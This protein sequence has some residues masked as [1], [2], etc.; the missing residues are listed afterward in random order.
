MT[1]MLHAGAAPVEYDALRE[2]TVPA[3]TPS[4]VPMGLAV[5]MGILFVTQTDQLVMLCTILCVLGQQIV[6]KP[7]KIVALLE[8]APIG[9]DERTSEGGTL[10]V[11]ASIPDWT[12]IPV[13]LEQFANRSQSQREIFE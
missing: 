11:V 3:A 7:W 4:H 1:L 12:G 13:A 9:D 2:L 8:H 10:P 5:G 6:W